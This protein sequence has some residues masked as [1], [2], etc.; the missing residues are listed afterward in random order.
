[1]EL[2]IPLH[3]IN[4]QGRTITPG[5]SGF[6]V[7]PGNW[8]GFT[9]NDD[10]LNIDKLVGW[11]IVF[12]TTTTSAA[13]NPPAGWTNVPADSLEIKIDNFERSGNKPV[14]F[15]IFNGIAVP[16]DQTSL[17]AFTWGQ[18]SMQ[19]ETNKGPVP[20]S[21]ALHWV[22]GDEWG[23][24]W[25]G[26]GFN[27]A[28]AFN[29][30][31]G[32]SVD[33]LHFTMKA[34]TGVDSMRVQFED[35][36][37]QVGYV[38]NVVQDTLWHNYT[39]ALRDINARQ[40]QN[41]S[42][43]FNPGNI[44]VWQIMSQADGK[45]GKNVYL[46]NIWTGN[47]KIDVVPPAAPTGVS[48]IANGDNSNTIIWTDVPG[49]KNE[50]YSVYYSLNQI[51]DITAKGV[52]VAA[53]GI[54]H[55][56]NLAIHKLIAPATDQNV[57]YYYAVVCRNAAGILGSPGS[58]GGATTNMATGVAIISPEPPANFQADGDISEW[59]AAGI[60]PFRLYSSDNSGTIVPGSKIA[61]DTISSGDVYVAVDKDYLYVAGHINT[62]NVYFDAA[63][64]SW[65]NTAT[66]LFLG[67][68]NW[69]GASH[70]SLVGGASPD[71]HFRFAKDRVIVDNFGIDS[72]AVPG[73][74]YFWDQRFPDP[75][76]GY[77]FEAKISWDDIAHKANGGNTRTDNV[78]VPQIGMRIPFD[79][80]LG[81]VTTGAT[82]RDGQLDYSSIANGN[83]YANVA[84]WTNTW[85]GDQWNVT[86][87]KDKS[88]GTVNGYN[89]SQNYPNPFNPSTSIRY[90]LMKPGMV[91]LTVYDI[92]GRRVSTLV[93]NYQTAGAHTVS[94][95]ASKLASGVYIYRIN[96]GNFQSVKKM[97]LLK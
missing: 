37:A 72:L 90:N 36:T 10:K 25:N 32:W 55:G 64:S 23:S 87:V 24:G 14:P 8:G 73:P 17:T 95:D 88:A 78:F 70:T 66:D 56:T 6:V 45:V 74:N 91:T 94:F 82:Q 65:L 61:N 58:T 41:L 30:S 44:T 11:N 60:K 80:E 46:T 96:A 27:V 52:E 18:A 69:H 57:S 54:G 47:P 93:N 77:N 63:N 4:S 49:Q 67:L 81:T 79:I 43:P 3:E 53:T 84:V 31:G 68:Y 21:N 15:V 40:D 71:Y 85:I 59:E 76:A 89:L 35:G 19:V 9:Y 97:M 28:P 38:F 2:K 7:A 34:D 62:N 29:L 16:S 86:G 39:V 33:S 83:S 5:D 50:S 51:T 26:V 48:V 1:M 92:L 13:P 22:M 20:N 12:V 42:T 75:M